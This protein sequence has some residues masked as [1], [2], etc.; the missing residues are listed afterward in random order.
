MK[1][2]ID[3]GKFTFVLA[4][5]A[6]LAAT[7][8]SRDHDAL[9]ARP[10]SQG[11]TAGMAGSAGATSGFGGSGGS[12]GGKAGSGGSGGTGGSKVTEPTG[13]SVITFLHALADAKA[14]TL[15]FAKSD[16]GASELVGR[17]RPAA[18]LVYG[19]ALVLEILSGVDLDADGVVPFV[20]TGELDLLDGLDC[21]EAVTLAEAEMQAGGSSAG[22][23]SAANDAGAAGQAGDGGGGAPN[24]VPPRLRVAQLPELA[25]GTLTEGYSLLYAM[26]GCL[27]GPAFH[28]DEREELCGAGY[29]TDRPNVTAELVVLSRRVGI[30]TIAIQALHASRALPAL[31]FRVKPPDTTLEPS[32][33]IADNVTEGMLRPRV[34]RTDLAPAG[35][36]VGTRSWSVQALVGTGVVVSDNWPT[37]LGR[38]DLEA[39]MSGRGYTLVVM[40]PYTDVDAPLWNPPGFTL[41]DNDPMP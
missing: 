16:G 4:A 31:S 22:E 17:P 18:G 8:C 12:F 5:F 34:P 32:A 10:R 19:G 40:G 36:G 3:A 39:P 14:V 9:A 28:H 37:I 11:G 21:E 25:P 24:L 20:I 23:A 15:C 33:F 1:P 2:C 13:R 30:G 7:D 35:Y 27:G 41:V 6:A 38:S 29:A 26:V